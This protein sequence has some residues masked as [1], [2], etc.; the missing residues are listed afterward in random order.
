MMLQVWNQVCSED[1]LQSYLK[2][3][4]SHQPQ[5]CKNQFSLQRFPHPKAPTLQR[6]RSPPEIL[7][8]C[9]EGTWRGPQSLHR[10][11]SH[12]ALLPRDR[13]QSRCPSPGAITPVERPDADRSSQH[14]ALDTAADWPANPAF[15]KPSQ[16]LL[17]R[18]NLSPS[19][20]SSG[21]ITSNAC[22]KQ[23]LWDQIPTRRVFRLVYGNRLQN[24][25]IG[26]KPQLSSD[27]QRVNSNMFHLLGKANIHLLPKALDYRCWTAPPCHWQG[28]WFSSPNFKIYKT[29]RYTL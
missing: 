4:N 14:S 21:M 13:H 25:A 7:K 1:N 20:F 16:I 23:L 9:V 17:S 3:F 12:C 10:T 19:P 6:G 15:C 24:M 27:G 2:D 5:G 11:P 18:S 8:P 22:S 28:H 26:Y 29:S